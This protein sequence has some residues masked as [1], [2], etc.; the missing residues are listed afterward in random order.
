[1]AEDFWTS[2][3]FLQILS[4]LNHSFNTWDLKSSGK[5]SVTA[6][7]L[8][9]FRDAERCHSDSL[10]AVTFLILLPGSCKLACH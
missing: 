8:N 9:W 3:M 7:S 4:P 1:M 10:H 5:K 2:N 6:N